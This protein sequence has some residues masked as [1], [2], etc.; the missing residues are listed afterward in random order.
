MIQ[1]QWFTRRHV[2]GGTRGECSTLLTVDV[3]VA[4]VERETSVARDWVFF[5]EV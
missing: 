2:R 3:Q 5:H 1:G 4:R